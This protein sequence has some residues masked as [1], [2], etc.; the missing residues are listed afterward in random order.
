MSRKEAGKGAGVQVVEDLG[1]CA[2]K[3]G[4]Y[5][6]QRGATEELSSRDGII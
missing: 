4:H 1:S 5:W 3:I 6:K 2:R